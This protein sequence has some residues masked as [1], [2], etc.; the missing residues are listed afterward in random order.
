MS[1]S[2]PESH[3]IRHVARVVIEF[4]TPFHVGTGQQ[5]YGADQTV[6]TDF[7]GLPA[8]PGASLA[9]ALRA[10]FLAE[11]R[12]S[13]R[14]NKLFGC[15]DGA[16]GRGSRL[17]LSWA[18]I[19]NQADQPVDCVL[20]RSNLDGDPVLN[21]A[22]QLGIRDHV[23][24][25]H[26]GAAEQRG[27]FDEQRVA[28]GHRFTFEMELVSQPSESD[29]GDLLSVL[30][31]GSLR[32][33]GKSRR[34]WGVFT[35]KQ[36]SS[37]SF[38]LSKPED[39]E[40]YAKHP[41]SLGEPSPG[42]AARSLS[43]SI[44]PAGAVII[45]IGLQPRGFWMFGGGEDCPPK[46]AAPVDMAPLREPRITWSDAG[47]KVEESVL[48]IPGS[49][50]KGAISHRVCFHDNRLQGRFA[51]EIARDCSNDQAGHQRAEQ[52][53]QKLTGERNTAVRNLF[54]FAN[55]A[56]DTARP[57][58]RRGRVL[59]DDIFLPTARKQQRISHISIDRFTGG[60]ADSHLFSERPVWE[61]DF[62]DLRMVI[63]QA[64]QVCRN[65]RQAL[66]ATLKDIAEGRLGLG[67]GAGRGLGYF[68]ATDPASPVH[69]SAGEQWFEEGPENFPD[70][71]Y[72]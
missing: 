31:N 19:H 61:G 62:P 30:G 44:V 38:N 53:L 67:A 68:N 22:L 32:L 26:R 54:G 7:N 42:L 43:T 51:N 15:Q 27:K 34:G 50:I 33:G 13:D 17:S 28:A 1:T 72:A 41:A 56:A 23:R 14:V 18:A 40:E 59:I 10:A 11:T 25:S 35:V 65:S 70:N 20:D 4:N 2:A 57:A 71:P 9:G 66:L 49:A 24:L 21:Q 6:V 52:A 3:P 64:D 29:W 60:A 45:T 58:A 63:L 16:D 46:N 55:G 36:I 37:R 39:F 8:I 5:G 69:C 12:D 48:V 47:G